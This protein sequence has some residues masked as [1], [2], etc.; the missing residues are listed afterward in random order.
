[1][2]ILVQRKC[3]SCKEILHGYTP[4]YRAI[5]IP[6]IRCGYCSVYNRYNHINEWDLKTAFS[7]LCYIGVLLWTSILYAMVGPIVALGLGY[8]LGWQ[9]SD[10]LL[11]ISYTIAVVSQRYSN[12]ISCLAAM[13]SVSS[14]TACASS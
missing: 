14:I 4:D 12:K 6:F 13:W 2:A 11:V 5:G 9:E 1:M 8:L 7:K 3:W 10:Q